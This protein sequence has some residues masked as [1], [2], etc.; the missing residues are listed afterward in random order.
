MSWAKVLYQHP[1]IYV[2]FWRT[3][4]DGAWRSEI[5]NVANSWPN[6]HYESRD[7]AG[8]RL[9]RRLDLGFPLLG[10]PHEGSRDTDG[11][12]NWASFNLHGGGEAKTAV[13]KLLAIT[14]DSSR[15]NLSKLLK[16]LETVDYGFIGTW[17]ES[18]G[19]EDAIGQEPVLK[20]FDDY[21]QGAAMGRKG[22]GQSYS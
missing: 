17:R 12:N 9:H 1:E 18:I 11:G 13:D 2:G 14:S 19:F 6:L 21:S 7:L 22:S 20:N 4:V 16:K 10:H 3:H 15:S 8:S 5:C